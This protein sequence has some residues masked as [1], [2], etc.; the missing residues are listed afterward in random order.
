LR[1]QIGWKKGLLFFVGLA[2]LVL[3]DPRLWGVGPQPLWVPAAGLGLVLTAWL[4]W[5]GLLAAF[6]QAL[7]VHLLSPGPTDGASAVSEGVFAVVELLVAWWGFHYLARGKRRLNDPVSATAFL[8]IVP[9]AASGLTALCRFAWSTE[10]FLV[11]LAYQWLSHAISLLAVAPVLLFNVTPW[12]NRS[13][14][15]AP[16]DPGEEFAWI[17]PLDRWALGDAVETGGLAVGST[18]LGV[19]LAGNHLTRQATSWHL[20]AVLLLLVVWASLRQ[21]LRGGSFS[22]CSAAV[23][24]LVCAG[25]I[26]PGQPSLTALQGNL[27]ALG[28]TALL[29]GGSSSWI[30]ARERRYRQVIGHI[31]VVLYSARL[32]GPGRRG[33]APR[34]QV[35]LASAAAEQIFGCSPVRLLGDYQRWLER[36]HPD[37]RELLI[38]A[39]AQ[40]VRRPEPVR[41]EYRLDPRF[42]AEDQGSKME[43]HGIMAPAVGSRPSSLDLRRAT[44][45]WVRDTLAPNYDSAGK[46]EGWEG[47][48]EDISAQRRLAQDLQRTTTMLNTLVANLPAGVFFVQGPAG[49]PLLVNTRAR[50]LLGQREDPSAS[51]SHWPRLYRIYRPDGSL[52]PW[53]EL[54]VHRALH[55]GLTIMADDLVIHRPDGR[56]VPLVTW[57]APIQLGV[58]GRVE[59]AVWVFEDRTSLQQA[60]MVRLD[61]EARLRGIIQNMP[62][63]LL[64]QDHKGVIIEC[65]PAACAFLGTEAT[66]LLGGSS[67]AN[68]R[69]M[70]RADGA[71]VPPAE[72]PDSVALRTLE[73][74]RNVVIGLALEA[75]A[76]SP[77]DEPSPVRWLRISCI[78]FSTGRAGKP[79]FVLQLI[80]TI[81][82]I[83]VERR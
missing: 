67:L 24:A 15:V 37:D 22:Y 49:L 19:L 82:G 44:E 60:E 53:E 58:E 66:A 75:A 7:V 17:D 16:D 81:T 35:I 38:A 73:S 9:G 63:G 23:A 46:L 48:V 57:A 56:Q 65:N 10:P 80:T 32:L 28:S 25:G 62:E 74:V 33:E 14:A 26:N 20:W 50:S 61:I 68:G 70:L 42:F 41:C 1:L 51:L 64:I 39:L 13:G 54:P 31:P 4:G 12:L 2:G 18:F 6:L 34:A 76:Q 59:A 8:L 52:Y 71:P 29:V 78:P 11:S 21:G 5:W 69:Q 40:L 45:R 47:V 43:D 83:D 77:E 79:G 36:V 55:S 72:Q 27:L 3:A 30:R